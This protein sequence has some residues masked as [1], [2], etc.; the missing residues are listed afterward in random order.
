MADDFRSNGAPILGVKWWGSYFDTINE[1]QVQPDGS[2]ASVVEDGFVISFHKDIPADAAGNFSRPGELLATY[3]TWGVHIKPTDEIGWDGHRI[4]EYSVDLED[5]HP[6]HLDPSIALPD[7]FN[8]VA[9]EIYWMSIVAENGHE[10]DEDWV[11]TA[12]NDPVELEHYWGWHTSPD[13]FNDVPV[14][15]DLKMPDAATWDYGNW[16]PVT[17]EHMPGDMA[18]ELYTVP[19]PSTVTLLLLGVAI[20][21]GSWR[22][23]R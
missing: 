1:P 19:E 16:I 7:R 11:T 3:T 13:R 5:T 23:R 4:W 17:L 2:F 8:E 12:N 22:K 9:G 6:E 14:M 21:F 20:G 15:G 10:M 18:F